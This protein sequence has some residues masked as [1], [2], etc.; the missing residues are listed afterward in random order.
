MIKKTH[1]QFCNEVYSLSKNEYT[2]LGHYEKNSIK[3][4]MKHNECGYEYE[5]LPSNFLKG[6]RCPKCFGTPKK[7]TEKFME[8]VFRKF[9][10]EYKVLDEYKTNNDKI[11]IKHAKCNY[12]WYSLPRHLLSGHLCPM[13]GG[14]LKKDT[15]KFKKQI[16]HIYKD[17]IIIIGE[18]KNSNTKIKVKCSVDGYE[19]EAYPYNL[20]KGSSCPRCK[21]NERYTTKRF[22][23]KIFDLYNDEYSILDQYVNSKSKILI[24]HNKC[25]HTWRVSPSSILSGYGCPKCNESRG[26]KKI[27]AYLEKK[28]IKYIQEYKFCDCKYKR[29]LPFDFYLPD[30]NICIEYDGE[31]HFKAYRFSD[32]EKA[33]KKLSII[34]IRDEIKTNYC[35]SNNITLIRIPYTELKN[36]DNFLK[37]A[38]P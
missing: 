34:Q 12:K 5:V 14:N 21:G 38:I 6:R 16:F 20:L 7:T 30:Y 10:D 17:K 23:E 27:C 4:R 32:R 33:I 35:K 3:I 29:L 22:E 28:K 9:G 26:E 2:V 15:D 31:Q 11:L 18:Y 13:C 24:R 1:E 25:N 36:I 37:S 19:W 8:E